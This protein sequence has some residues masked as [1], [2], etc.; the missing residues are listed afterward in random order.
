MIV[1]EFSSFAL[2]IL[3]LV[4]FRSYFDTAFLT[5]GDFIWRVIVITIVSCLPLYILK[6]IQIKCNPPIQQKLMQYAT[7][8]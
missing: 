7:L 4:I 5:S 2:Y 8:K 1:A 6:F 3:S